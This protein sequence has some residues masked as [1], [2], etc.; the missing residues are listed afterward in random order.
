VVLINRAHTGST[1]ENRGS[2]ALMRRMGESRKMSCAL[3]V[4]VLEVMPLL[5]VDGL[6]M[7]RDTG[8]V[9]QKVGGVPGMNHRGRRNSP[10]D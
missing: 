8:G 5:G 9:R 4:G 2:R 7:P 10:A 3:G 6:Q 1:K